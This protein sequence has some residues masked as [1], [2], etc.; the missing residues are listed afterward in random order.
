[1]SLA[2]FN[3]AAFTEV[4]VAADRIL[5]V[6]PHTVTTRQV[7]AAIGRSDSV[8]RP[9]MKRLV[10]GGILSDPGTSSERRVCPFTRS[11]P[12]AWEPLLA[13][14]AEATDAARVVDNVNPP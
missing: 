1:M 7:A 2:L 10:A 12:G 9:V 14:I 5:E 3:N 11:R 8:V 4:V 13:L 6:S